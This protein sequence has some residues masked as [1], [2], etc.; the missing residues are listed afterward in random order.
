[1]T[2]DPTLSASD[3]SRF[4]FPALCY[5]LLPALFALRYVNTPPDLR[6]YGPS[7]WFLNYHNGFVRRALVGQVFSHFNYLSWRSIFVVEA[8]ILGIVVVCTYLVFR[9]MLFGTLNERR[10]SAFLLAAPA[11]LPHLAYMGGEMDNFLY[12][13]LLAGAFCLMRLR[14]NTGLLAVTLFSALGLVLHEGFLLMF[15]PLVLVLIIELIH[16]RRLKP[17]AVG[18]HLAVIASCFLSIL[19]FGKMKG[20]E[21]EWVSRAQARTDMPIE[22]TVFVALHNSLGEQVHFALTHYTISL[23]ARV[24][25][26]LL[27]CI[28]YEVVLWRL[29]ISVIEGRGYSIGLQRTV[30][31]LFLVPLL[32]IPLG[33]DAMRWI[34]ALC[35][36]ISLYM[37]F[38]YQTDNRHGEGSGG[39]RAL[40]AN[41]N[42][43]PAGMATF[44]Y[45]SVLGPWGL[46]G[47]RLFANLANLLAR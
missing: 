41:W 20:L 21:A 30:C 6:T 43:A 34:A 38:L 32:L 16:Q 35:I 2:I 40:L 3:S 5:A 9:S 33:H 7:H 1:M 4:N 45:L 26:T 24:A 28:P 8:L 31:C 39:M 22:R 37:L 25:L 29:L 46:A 11:F 44:L 23:V 42:A 18:I 12:M 36:N 19:H 47:N 17:A 14:S 15:Y 27:M 13:A 10:F